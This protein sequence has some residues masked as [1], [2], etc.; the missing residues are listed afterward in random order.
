MPS[1]IIVINSVVLKGRPCIGLSISIRSH[2]TWG[3]YGSIVNSVAVNAGH[4]YHYHHPT[5][6]LKGG[7][8][9]IAYL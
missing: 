1:R 6:P 3:W 4:V 9:D 7:Y 5:L 8:L 2:G